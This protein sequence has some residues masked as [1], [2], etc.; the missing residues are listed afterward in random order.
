M[1]IRLDSR[2]PFRATLSHQELALIMVEALSLLRVQL[3]VDRLLLG[4]T[5]DC[6]SRG[7]IVQ[8][9]RGQTGETAATVRLYLDEILAVGH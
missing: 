7:A 3:H 1:F 2:V 8:E 9:L 4:A 6:D 5:Y